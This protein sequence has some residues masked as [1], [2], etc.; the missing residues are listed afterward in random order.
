MAAQFSLLKR[1]N[2]RLCGPC[3]VAVQKNQRCRRWPL[4]LCHSCPP[5]RQQLAYSWERGEFTPGGFERPNCKA[6]ITARHRGAVAA[7]ARSA[8]LVFLPG[9][10]CAPSQASPWSEETGRCPHCCVE[11]ALLKVPCNHCSAV[12]LPLCRSAAPC[13][14]T[15]SAS[16]PHLGLHRR[17]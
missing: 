16:L 3:G 9:K 1:I 11:R 8:A 12:L 6:H 2:A 10:Q 13:R 5:R 14:R 4:D 7:S 15:A 17:P